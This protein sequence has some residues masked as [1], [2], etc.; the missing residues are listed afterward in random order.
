MI[1][2]HLFYNCSMFTPKSNRSGTAILIGN[3]RN[4]GP[5]WKVESSSHSSQ[6]ARS[7]RFGTV[8]EAATNRRSPSATSQHEPLN[9][10]L[11][12]THQE[13]EEWKT[14]DIAAPNMLLHRFHSSDYHL[15]RC[16]SI[17]SDNVNLNHKYRQ[18]GERQ[19]KSKEIQQETSSSITSPN[20]PRIP[21][22]LRQLRV[23]KSHFSCVCSIWAARV[24]LFLLL[25]VLQ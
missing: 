22:K 19:M 25:D 8:A 13:C 4:S 17:I 16:T 11:I 2:F 9:S 18:T 21:E 10:M 5:K 20:L 23:K 6:L 1:R 7:P 12:F 15:Q 3:G 24:L 14:F